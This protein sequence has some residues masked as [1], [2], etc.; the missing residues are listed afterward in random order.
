MK[1]ALL[2]DIHG[3]IAALEAV[4]AD[5]RARGGAEIINLGDSLSGPLYPAETANRLMA[6]G[7]T[8]IQGNHERQLQG[9]PASMNA[10]D[11]YAHRQLTAAHRDWIASQP[12]TLWLTEDVFLCHGTPQSDLDYFLETIEP[13]ATRAAT[14]EEATMRAGLITAALILCGHSHTPRQVTLTDGRIVLNPGSV[15]LQ[16]YDWDRPYPHKMETGSPKARYAFLTKSPGGWHSEFIAVDY[17]WET[18][19]RRAETNDRP[20]WARALRSGSA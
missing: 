1:L 5:I 16:A 19:A 14:R 20:D 4:L 9:N 17:D 15:G 8:S 11:A 2:S 3:N 7:I 10:S 13:S 18:A 12:A 6:L